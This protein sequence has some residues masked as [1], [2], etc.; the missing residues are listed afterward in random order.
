MAGSRKASATSDARD[1][2][3][4]R[5]ADVQTLQPLLEGFRELGLSPYEAR[6]V[7]ALLRRG[8]ANSVQL[9][10]LSGVP[11]TAVYPVLQ[12]LGRKALVEQV[13]GSGPAVWACHSRDRVLGALRAAEEERLRQ[14]NLRAADV[15]ALLDRSVPEISSDVAKPFVRVIGDAR[16]LKA[17]Y[18]EVL[19]QAQTDVTMSARPAAAW[20]FVDPN[21]TVL[22]LLARDVSIRILY[23]AELWNDPSSEA[24]RTA[25]T[26]YHEAGAEAR[27]VESL[28]LHVVVVDHRDV[29]VYMTHPKSGSYPITLH[30]EHPRFADLV[31]LAFEQL[32]TTARPLPEAGTPESRSLQAQKGL[33]STG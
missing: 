21:R 31:M 25:M 19:E 27:L 23:E 7:V 11:R 22:D 28:S 14:H 5:S 15:R 24:F 4:N 13:P 30:V 6:V 16:H 18:S 17:A 26:T 10:E 3:R 8:T 33:R 9:A 20:P 29:V 1:A 2:S 12:G 32:W